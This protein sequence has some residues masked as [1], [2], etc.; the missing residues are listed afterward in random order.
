VSAD[1]ARLPRYSI[2]TVT[3]GHRRVTERFLESVQDCYGDRLGSEVE[4]VL[5]DNASPDDTP[6]LLREWEDRAT[7]ILRD[8]NANFAG[9]NNA[10]ARAARGDVLILLNNDT[11]L[12]EPLD[13]LVDQVREPGVGIA[14]CRLLYPDGTI[15][16]GGC[17]W[18]ADPLGRVLPFHLFQFESGDLPAAHATYDGDAVTGACLAIERA[19][20]LKLGGLD[21]Q[22]VNGLEDMDLCVR[23]RLSGHRVVYRGDIAVIHAEG[24]SRSQRPDDEL[25]QHRFLSRYNAMLTADGE[26]F[27]A[28][29]GAVQANAAAGIRM[30][31]THPS[32]TPTGVGVSIEGEIG[33]LADESA[34]A[35]ALLHALERAGLVPAARE[36]Q[37]VALIPPLDPDERNRLELARM[38]PRRRDALI[39]QAPVGELGAI[40]VHP[41]AILRLAHLPQ[42]DIASVAAVWAAHPALADQ[43]VVAGLDA[44][45][46]DVVAPL[47]AE[48]IP[49][50]GGNG[51]LA[52][53]PGHDLDRCGEILVA[54]A[55][56]L[57]SVAIRLLPTVATEGLAALVARSAPS[58]E[59]LAPIRG[60]RRFAELAG[61]CDLVLHADPRDR[62]ERRALVAAATGTAVI[63]LPDATAAAILG[64]DLGFDGS[65]DVVAAGLATA[66]DR[67]SRTRRVMAVCGPEVVVPQVRELIRRAAA[68]GSGRRPL[69]RVRLEAPQAA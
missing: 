1:P 51:V 49:G 63:H 10:A 30:V 36:W 5:V 60:E 14:G 20:F 8:T 45:R 4:L 35:R 29:F 46:V 68:N 28:L 11:E 24:T 38:R 27:A 52:V 7:V 9:G 56:H 13:A 31:W 48:A 53:L 2:L 25:N 67:A 33:G 59:L 15:Q 64:S 62:F 41:R 47:V 17:A 55:P 26:R 57:T 19:L 37:P 23:A 69:R 54:L 43:L 40:D 18:A 34:E 21:E 16:H 66:G 61:Q 32:D 65:P 50:I 39:V 12:L 6:E 44:D 3:Y 58:A 22:Y 42:E